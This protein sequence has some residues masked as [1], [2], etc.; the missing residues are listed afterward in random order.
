[1]VQFSNR[2]ACR[3]LRYLVSRCKVRVALVK[4]TTQTITIVIQKE[5]KIRMAVEMEMVKDKDAISL[6]S[7][8]VKQQGVRIIHYQMQDQH[9]M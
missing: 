9:S 4:V 5:M 7:L 2:Q 6:Q 3:I 1:M 8:E